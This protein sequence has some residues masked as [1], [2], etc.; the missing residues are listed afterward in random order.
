MSARQMAGQRV[1]YSYNGL[2]AP[3]W[4]LSDIRAGLVGGV[5]F[6]SFNIS[7]EP[8]ISGV[9]KQLAAANASS[10]NPARKFPLLLMT[11]QE[12]G[13]VR[14]L[15]GGPL[16]SEAQIGASADPAAAAATAGRSAAANLR[17]R[18]PEREP[19]AGAGRVPA[20]G[21]LR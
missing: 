17:G 13:L 5:I 1:I 12:G 16:E 14:R 4:P 6:F 9:V 20:A 15:P 11:D 21:R 2:S 8:Q 19:G 10:G 18:R 3:A 7:S